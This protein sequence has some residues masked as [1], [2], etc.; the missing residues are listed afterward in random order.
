[1]IHG[2]FYCLPAS[3]RHNLRGC[4]QLLRKPMESSWQ[5]L[6]FMPEKQIL[7]GKHYGA[8]GC[9]N[10]GFVT[11][12]FT[13]QPGGRSTAAYLS[14]HKKQRNFKAT[15]NN[16]ELIYAQFC[17]SAGHCS[18]H[19]RNAVQWSLLL[20]SALLPREPPFALSARGKG[21]ATKLLSVRNTHRQIFPL[22][23]P[24]L[25][26]VLCSNCIYLSVRHG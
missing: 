15:R 24:K 13:S 20:P 6:I 10:P 12:Y 14:G 25:N 11:S 21:A 22:S 4:V 26:F 8:L 19:Q 2:V 3:L 16:R 23:F 9:F 18:T 5:L 1:M 17:C 7:Q